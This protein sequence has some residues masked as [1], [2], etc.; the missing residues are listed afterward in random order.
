[1]RLI[2]QICTYCKYKD[3]RNKL[4]S[5]NSLPISDQ[6]NTDST[7]LKLSEDSCNKTYNVFCINSTQ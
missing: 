7:F 3:T 2:I 5:H 6:R 1:V 4:A